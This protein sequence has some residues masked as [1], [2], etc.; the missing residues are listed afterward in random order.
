MRKADQHNLDSWLSDHTNTASLQLTDDA[1]GLVRD[2]DRYTGMVNGYYFDTDETTCMGHR[3]IRR[4]GPSRCR[5]QSIY[6]GVNG[7][8]CAYERDLMLDNH[9]PVVALCHDLITFSVP[10]KS[11]ADSILLGIIFYLSL[12]LVGLALSIH[13]LFGAMMLTGFGVGL[14]MRAFQSKHYRDELGVYNKEANFIGNESA[15][16]IWLR[17]QDAPEELYNQLFDDVPRL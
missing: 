16:R 9:S 15:L 1:S 6:Q 13:L 8:Y 7:R 5:I 14:G 10:A 3:V 2:N 17:S 12:G 11:A 4:Y